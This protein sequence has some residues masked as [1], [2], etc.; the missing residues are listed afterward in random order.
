MATVS[1]APLIGMETVKGIV[2]EVTADAVTVATVAPKIS[3]E[4][5]KA[6]TLELGDWLILQ[7]SKEGEYVLKEKI[8]EERSYPL[9]TFVDKRKGVAL[10]AV[11]LDI[12]E[13]AA[14]AP[15][16]YGFSPALGNVFI[17]SAKLDKNLVYE[18]FVAWAPRYCRTVLHFNWI[19]MDEAVAVNQV[20]EESDE[21][22][23]RA[24][25]FSDHDDSHLIRNRY[26][27]E[28][29]EACQ[30]EH[31]RHLPREER[32]V[33]ANLAPSGN[34]PHQSLEMQDVGPPT[35]DVIFRIFS[36]RDVLRAC[37]QFEPQLLTE[38][39]G[40]ILSATPNRL[41]Q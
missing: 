33:Q 29:K 23:S 24:V 26:E 38:L 8:V 34:I 41:S 30:L 11:K 4:M 28:V 5:P 31:T 32:A 12:R 17:S 22:V 18:G 10:L 37:C 2:V 20:D 9:R 35:W 15:R 3:L 39:I 40:L 7:L 16:L 19:L 6:V 27:E 14:V 25:C 21:N 13:N 1:A 36:N